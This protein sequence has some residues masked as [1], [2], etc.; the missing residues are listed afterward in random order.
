MAK[1]IESNKYL[2]RSQT[3]RSTVETTAVRAL[4]A[5]HSPP[6]S[7]RTRPPPGQICKRPCSSRGPP[8][9]LLVIGHILFLRLTRKD[10]KDPLL[11]CT[12]SKHPI[13]VCL[14]LPVR[15]QGLLLR[16]LLRFLQEVLRLLLSRCS[17]NL[18][19]LR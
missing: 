12:H 10:T 4:H 18:L 1:K 7:S 11:L 15:S 9:L 8:M 2:L 13:K 17:R 14:N 5:R 16:I 19:C 6:Q 3:C